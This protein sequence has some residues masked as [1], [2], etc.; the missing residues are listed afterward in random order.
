MELASQPKPPKEEMEVESTKGTK[1][2]CQLF[3]TKVSYT[4]MS[5]APDSKDVEAD[6][7]ETGHAADGALSSSSLSIPIPRSML[8]AKNTQL[9]TPPSSPTPSCEDTVPSPASN[10][11]NRENARQQLFY[12]L[13]GV[14]SDIVGF[15]ADGELVLDFGT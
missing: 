11:Q 8:S 13:V 4:D 2:A 10:K 14:A 3:Y 5:C 15:D 9:P 1:P 6:E 12:H 7:K